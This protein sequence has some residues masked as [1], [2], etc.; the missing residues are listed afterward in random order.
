MAGN[1]LGD[2]GGGEVVGFE[3]GEDGMGVFGVLEVELLGGGDG[4]R[5]GEKARGFEEMDGERTR[6]VSVSRNRGRR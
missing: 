1:E 4:S 6:W 5:G 2:V 3:E